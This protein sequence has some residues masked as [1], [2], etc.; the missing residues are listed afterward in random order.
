MPAFLHWKFWTQ[1][2]RKHK[3]KKESQDYIYLQWH[4]S[5]QERT[6][7]TYK[8]Y[9][10]V[11]N[12]AQSVYSDIQTWLASQ[13]QSDN[14]NTEIYCDCCQE[15][16]TSNITN[17]Q[18]GAARMSRRQ[19]SVSTVSTVSSISTSHCSCSECLPY[20]DISDDES[21]YS[22]QLRRKSRD[23]FMAV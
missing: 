13:P 1:R 12:I 2:Q 22:S 4:F 18:S 15:D 14:R 10:V 5:P 9:D 17:N 19:G 16:N 21:L 20:S 6:E 11:D 7:E 8:T 23:I 3:A